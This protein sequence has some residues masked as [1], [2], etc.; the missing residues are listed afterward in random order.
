VRDPAGGDFK[1]PVDR[2]LAR[3]GD[4]ED[5]LKNGQHHHD[6]NR[7]AGQR[8]QEDRIQPA[9]PFGWNWRPVCR[10]T[11]DF[12]GPRPAF[13]HILQHRQFLGRRLRHDARQELV[14]SRQPFAAARAHQRHRRA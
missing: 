12:T 9:G 13:R 7:R 14:H 5:R 6:E 11:A 4:A 8:M 2:I 3:I 10:L 1:E